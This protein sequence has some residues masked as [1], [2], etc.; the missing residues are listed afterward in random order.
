MGF[1]AEMKPT[2]GLVFRASRTYPS[3]AS[4][5]SHFVDQSECGDQVPHVGRWVEVHWLKH[6]GKL[7]YLAGRCT[8]SIDVIG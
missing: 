7:C 2:A 8:T 6:H 1:A 4:S 5:S 3:S